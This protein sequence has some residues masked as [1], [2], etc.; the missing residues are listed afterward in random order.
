MFSKTETNRMLSYHIL[1]IFFMSIVVS[2]YSDV[3]SFELGDYK[4]NDN[5]KKKL[6]MNCG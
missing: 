2:D 3:Q 6:S 5:A 4:T 1:Y